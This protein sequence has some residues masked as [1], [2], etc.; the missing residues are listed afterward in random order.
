[1][2]IVTL[3]LYHM[4]APDTADPPPSLP[5]L[6]FI[7]GRG[8]KTRPP[9]AD[10]I[11]WLCCRFG[12]TP[13]PDWP[14]APLLA[15]AAGLAAPFPGWLCADPVHLELH[16]GHATIVAPPALSL[17]ETE[18]AQVVAALDRHFRERDL[19]FFAFARN[20]WLINTPLPAALHSSPLPAAGGHIAS[21][22]DAARWNALLTEAQM[23]LHAHP[24]NAARQARNEPEV[25]SLHLWGA[26]VD[27]RPRAADALVAGDDPLMLALAAAATVPVAASAGDLLD[28][29]RS[30]AGASALVVPRAPESADAV[31]VCL[32]AIEHEWLAPLLHGVRRGRIDRLEVVAA[33]PQALLGLALAPAALWRVWGA[34]RALGRHLSKAPTP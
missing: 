21:G 24:V 17:S 9:Q 23:L 3:L 13:R 30:R 4:L 19:R 25:N 8:A 15:R 12:L 5:A 14:V 1:V 6:R 16:Q 29:V 27:A 2:R 10:A 31:A 34:M 33:Q 32:S 20:R 22:A 26:G 7:L 28:R 11:S 18:S